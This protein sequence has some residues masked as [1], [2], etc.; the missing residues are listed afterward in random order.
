M[1]A[2]AAH[3]M[4][5]DRPISIDAA[6]AK[7][8]PG[9]AWKSID[10]VS[11]GRV[12][13]LPAGNDDQM[14]ALAVMAEFERM[15]RLVPD[16]N[17]ARCAVIGR[18]WKSL[19]PVRSYCEL[20]GIPVQQADESSNGFWSLRETQALIAWLRQRSSQLIDAATIRQ[21]LE[22]KPE[23][24]PGAHWWSYLREAIAEYSLEVEEAELPLDHFFEW[25]AEWGREARRRQTG[26]LLLTAHKAKGLEFDHV[27]ILDGDWARTGADEDADAP[28][29]LYYVAMTRARKTLV[30]ARFDRG[31]VLA[32]ALPDSPALLRRPPTELPPPMPE[33]A[34]QYKRLGWGE[35]NLDYSGTR[36]MADAIHR[37]IA[38]L[39]VDDGLLLRQ[40]QSGVWALSDVHGAVV[41]KLSRA[42][43][44][45]AGMHCIKARVAAIHVRHRKDVGEEHQARLSDQ[46]EAWEMIVPE[47]V[48]APASTK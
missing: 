45:P 2:P 10:P 6:R 18:A 7:Q 30:L 20:K 29:R 38:A 8:P 31:H 19:D 42:F 43:S 13:I 27:A 21:W 28:R 47:L 26:L 22:T 5:T 40:E 41:G 44:P 25:L 37:N 11:Q 39:A 9:G 17:W 36:P 16:W 23:R 14:Q 32:D 35:I 46:C 48:F 12:Q 24:Q 15:S 4:K 1:I 33:L 34:N 3:R